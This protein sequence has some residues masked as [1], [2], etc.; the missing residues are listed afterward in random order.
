[1]LHVLYSD[2]FSM[3]IQTISWVAVIS[4]IFVDG[5]VLIVTC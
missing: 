3:F 2:R 5:F 4:R 1:M